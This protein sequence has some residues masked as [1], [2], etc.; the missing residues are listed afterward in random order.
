VLEVRQG[1][2]RGGTKRAD[3]R[4]ALARVAELAGELLANQVIEEFTLHES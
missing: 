4:A 3:G 1:S 2:V